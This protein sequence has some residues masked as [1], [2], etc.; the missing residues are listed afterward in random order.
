MCLLQNNNTRIM[1]VSKNGG[2]SWDPVQVPTV[3]PERVMSCNFRPLCWSS[4][5]SLEPVSYCTCNY[6]GILWGPSINKI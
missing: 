1:H 2:D 3:T 4:S 6:L 5:K